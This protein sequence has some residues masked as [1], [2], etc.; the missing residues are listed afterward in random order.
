MTDYWRH[1]VWIHYACGPLRQSTQ[2]NTA[3]K[4]HLI[5]TSTAREKNAF[6]NCG[7]TDK[8]TTTNAK[9][10]NVM[11]GLKQTSAFA[12]NTN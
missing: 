7:Q 8:V 6:W 12:V 1:K 10:Y 3:L 9:D 4:Y 2:K 11:F 5:R